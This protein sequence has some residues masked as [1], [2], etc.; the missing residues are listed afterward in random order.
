VVLVTTLARRGM[1][2]GERSEAELVERL[3]GG[4]AGAVDELYSRFGRS[5]YA[6]VRSLV[7]DEGLAE[8]IVQDAF[9]AARRGAGAFEG[10]SSL[11]SWLFG[12]ARRQ[13]RDRMRRVIPD[14]ES[15]DRLGEMPGSEAGPE[16][17]ALASASRA[18]LA[19]ALERIPA[20]DREVLLLAFA[21]QFLFVGYWFWEPARC[22]GASA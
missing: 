11:T 13:A 7:R 1:S 16:A 12:I 22:R 10:R 6:Y 21:Y 14:A 17:A 18:E 2:L 5:L 8:E 20:L 3:A 19:D 4:N 15:V 9:V